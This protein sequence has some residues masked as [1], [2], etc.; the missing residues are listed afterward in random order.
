MSRGINKVIR[1]K[2]A[3]YSSLSCIYPQ[4]HPHPPPTAAEPHTPLPP[5]HSSRAP[6]QTRPWRVLLFFHQ[7]Q[8]AAPHRHATPH[9]TTTRHRPY[10]RPPHTTHPNSTPL[11]ST[12]APHYTPIHPPVPATPHLTTTQY[13]DA[14]P[15]DHTGLTP[16]LTNDTSKSSAPPHGTVPPATFSYPLTHPR[17]INIHLLEA[18]MENALYRQYLKW[19]CRLLVFAQLFLEH[20]QTSATRPR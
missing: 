10:P 16:P 7:L 13:H 15:H 14:P 4:R 11:P 12:A 19:F 6:L 20:A 9:H 1:V 17:N 8:R 3:W 5:P 18:L 2:Q